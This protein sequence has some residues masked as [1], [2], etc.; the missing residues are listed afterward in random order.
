MVLKLDLVKAF[1]RVN[2]NFLRLLLIQIGIPLIGVNWIVGCVSSACFVVLVNGSPFDFFNASRGIRQGCLLPPLLFILIIESLGRIILN[3]HLVGHITDYQYTPDLSI[4]HLLFVDDV[5]LFGI[6]TVGEWKAYKEALDLFCSA[7]G[8]TVSIKKSSFLFQ[9]VDPDIRNQIV[10]FL[11]YSMVHISEGFKYLGFRLKPLGYRSSDWNWLVVR[12]EKKIKHW[13]FV[14]LSLGGRVILINVVLSGLAVY[15]FA[16]AR[17]PK[18]ILNKLRKNIFLFLW[19][20][21]D[22]HNKLHLTSWESVSILVVYGGWD[23][24]H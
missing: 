23:I 10:V 19:G 24:K 11:P 12:F 22:G 7:T 5:L 13:Y 8:M 21:S 6:G 17:C 2:W 1:D 20:S 14:L 18:S 3:A 9:N 15:W 16:L 4:T